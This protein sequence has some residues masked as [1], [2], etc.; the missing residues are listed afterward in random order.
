MLRN[1]AYIEET[2]Y[3][4]NGDCLLLHLP[5]TP[6]SINHATP[7]L[8]PPLPAVGTPGGVVGT[9]VGAFARSPPAFKK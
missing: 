5:V 9:P 2:W 7:A 4:A 6:S 3:E 1:N 8:G